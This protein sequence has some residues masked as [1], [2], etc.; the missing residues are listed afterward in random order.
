MIRPILFWGK[1]SEAKVDNE[2][3][4]LKLFTS[5]AN[6]AAKENSPVVVT[7]EH[8]SGESMQIVLGGDK[9]YLCYMTAEFSSFAS[10][11]D[12]DLEEDF[13]CY[14]HG[15]YSEVPN[16]NIIDVEAAI[17]AAVHFFNTK[18]MSTSIRWESS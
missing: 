9:S 10:V 18:G 14:I 1:A 13:V 3:E 5:I 6:E 16:K 8:K 15:E 2:D 7:I 17:G 12:S 4:L 11:G